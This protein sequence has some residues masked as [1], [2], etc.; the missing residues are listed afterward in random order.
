M[1]LL[2]KNKEFDHA[3]E[4]LKKHFPKSMVGKVS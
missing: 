4:V 1:G 3:N 2:I